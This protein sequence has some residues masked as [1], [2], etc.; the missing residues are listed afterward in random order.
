[1]TAFGGNPHRPVFCPRSASNPKSGINADML[2]DDGRHDAD[3]AASSYCVFDS[4]IEDLLDKHHLLTL[5]LC[6]Y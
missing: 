4:H 2:H 1:M 3:Q 5:L 6:G